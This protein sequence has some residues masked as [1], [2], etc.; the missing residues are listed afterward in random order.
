MNTKDAIDFLLNS[1]NNNLISLFKKYGNRDTTLGTD[2]NITHTYGEIYD[3]LFSKKKDNATNILEIGISGGFGLRC[4]AEYFKHAIIT[5]IDIQDIIK[6]DIRNHERIKIIIGNAN[7]TELIKTLPQFDIIIEDASHELR[8]QI[9]LFVEYYLLINPNG[10][11]IIEDVN[12]KNVDK[13][14]DILRPF[15]KEKGF[16]LSIYDGRDKSNRGDD[17]LVILQ[18]I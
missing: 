5:G 9:I 12:G 18:K 13:L 16:T 6:A 8:D 17:I 1:Q 4:Y 3:T 14:I 7:N 11:Y 2:K 15:A 10:L